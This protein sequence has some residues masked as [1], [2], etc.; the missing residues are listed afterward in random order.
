MKEQFDQYEALL[1]IE[2]LMD[3]YH[4]IRTNTH[5]KNKL[6][7]FELFF[8]C[9]LFSIYEVLK[10]KKYRHQLYHVFLIHEPKYRIIMSEVMSDKIVNHLV[11][12]Y[13]LFPLIEP[14]LIPMN[15]ATRPLKGTKAGIFYVKKYVNKLKCHYEKFYVL[16]CDI[17]KYFYSIDHEILFEKLKKIIRDPDVYQLLKEIITSTDYDYVNHKIKAVVDKENKRLEEKQ[18][19]DLFYRLQELDRIPYYQ[20]GKGLPIG[21]MTSQILAVFYLNELDHFIKEKLRIK[22]YVRYMDDFLL[23]HPD[24]DYLQMCYM[25]LVEKLQELKLHFN[26]K[27]QI[28]EVHHGF[29]FLGYRFRLKGKKLLILLRGKTKQKLRRKLRYLRKYHP[30][31]EE[32]VLASYYGYLKNADCGNFCYRHHLK[33]PK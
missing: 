1:H 21:N 6:L 18:V 10:Q 2:K 23:F 15:V 19:S 3:V 31:N 4:I 17:H 8:S 28:I 5:H 32:Q 26:Q 27:T 22:Y 7:V 11:S 29:C 30:E 16:K 14:K 12:K 25:R 9:N 24:R 33:I 13:I 20:K